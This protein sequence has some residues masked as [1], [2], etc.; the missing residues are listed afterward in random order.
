MP[1]HCHGLPE[2]TSCKSETKCTAHS[3]ISLDRLWQSPQ[4][5]SLPGH[6]TAGLRH[7]V[8]H[9]LPQNMK[10]EAEL[11]PIS[12]SVCINPSWQLERFIIA[13]LFVWTCNCARKRTGCRLDKEKTY[14]RNDTVLILKSQE[15]MS[16]KYFFLQSWQVIALLC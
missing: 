14:S 4:R 11:V 2:P 12:L 7:P 10:K 16:H 1:S 9:W 8:W 3:P 13:G 6:G 15:N 5:A